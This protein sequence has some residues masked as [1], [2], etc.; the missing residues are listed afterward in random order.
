[1]TITSAYEHDLTN[2]TAGASVPSEAGPVATPIPPGPRLP[3]RE[4]WLPLPDEYPDFEVRV[5]VNYPQRLDRD[6]K[7][8]DEQRIRTALQQIVLDHNGWVDDRGE[9]FPP[10]SDPQFWA[11]VPTELAVTCI[12]LVGLQSGKLAAS[13]R[14]RSAR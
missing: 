6:L 8:N 2:G 4:Q 10:A 9:P 12:A 11:D 14:A 13:L 3:R 5:W 1:M 7:S